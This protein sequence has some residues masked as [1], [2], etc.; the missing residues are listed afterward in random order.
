[1]LVNWLHAYIDTTAADLRGV[2]EVP[3]QQARNNHM[4]FYGIC[5]AVFYVFV[6]RADIFQHFRKH[7]VGGAP[8]RRVTGAGGRS[9]RVPVRPDPAERP[10]AA[11]GR[12]G[13]AFG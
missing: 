12:R 13:L 9:E 4:V 5:Q 11:A 10:G 1:M 8:A 6:N 3:P 2:G 7:A